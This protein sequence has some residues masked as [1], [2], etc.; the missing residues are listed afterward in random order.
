MDSKKELHTGDVIKL[1]GDNLDC[2]MSLIEVSHARE[3]A[4]M[5]AGNHAQK[6]NQKIFDFV[7][8]LYPMLEMYELLIDNKTGFIKIIT[9]KL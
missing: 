4:F 9:K 2:L 5:L 3:F 7:H 8:E 6:A 1:E